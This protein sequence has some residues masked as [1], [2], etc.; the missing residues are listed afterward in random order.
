MSRIIEMKIPAKE[1]REG[2]L[3]RS[4]RRLCDVMASL[5]PIDWNFAVVEIEDIESDYLIIRVRTVSGRDYIAF[6]VFVENEITIGRLEKT[7]QIKE[8]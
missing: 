6:R 1:V 3:L 8:G 5:G 4:Q 7:I 2:D